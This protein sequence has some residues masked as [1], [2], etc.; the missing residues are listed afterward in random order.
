MSIRFFV[1]FFLFVNPVWS[2][3]QDLDKCKTQLD[4]EALK[5]D[6][7]LLSPVMKLDRELFLLKESVLG[8]SQALSISAQYAK[9]PPESPEAF[10][11]SNAVQACNDLL[12]DF[13]KALWFKTAQWVGFLIG[14]V[15]IGSVAFYFLRRQKA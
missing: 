6:S 14:L 12:L 5:A 10:L 15:M 1:V 3:S 4:A 13:K 9:A 8:W 7:P 11:Y 2:D